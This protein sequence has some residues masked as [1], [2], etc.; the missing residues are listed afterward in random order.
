MTKV[1]LFLGDS[2]ELNP[3]SLI[4]GDTGITVSKNMITEDTDVLILDCA[5]DAKQALDW[6]TVRMQIGTDCGNTEDVD[7][8]QIFKD[9]DPAII[10]EIILELFDDNVEDGSDSDES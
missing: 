5:T 2:I 6:A 7:Y 3:D 1:A 10:G 8:H 4:L 9:P